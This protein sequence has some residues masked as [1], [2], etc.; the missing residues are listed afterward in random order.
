MTSYAPGA[1]LHVIQAR[2][3]LEEHESWQMVRLDDIGSGVI[4]LSVNGTTTQFRC[5]DSARLREVYTSGRVPVTK[6][7]TPIVFK[8]NYGVLVVPCADEGYTFPLRA[9]ILYS[10]SHVK[11][12]AAQYSPS[13]NGAWQLF[14]IDPILK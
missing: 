14:A 9:E 7:G 6:D 1:N 2:K 11:N 4:T 13:E 10:V 12:G 8:A 5:D 3:A